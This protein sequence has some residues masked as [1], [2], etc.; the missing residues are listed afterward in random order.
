[1][2]AHDRRAYLPAAVRSALDAGADEVVVVRNFDGPIDGCEGRFRDVRCDA[3]ETNEKEARG[4]EAATG[5]IVGFLDDD[6]LWEPGKGA[7]MRSAFAGDPDLVYLCHPQVPI[8]ADGRSTVARHRELAEKHPDRFATW[9]GRDFPLLVTSIW[10]G[11]NSST[12][13]R[14]AWASEWL[15]R[16]RDA[17]WAADLFWLVAAVESGRPFR[18][19]VEALTRLRLHDANMS[20]TRGASRSEFRQRHGVSSERFAR[21]TRV[22]TEIALE[23]AGPESSVTRYLSDKAAAFRFFAALEEGS[24]ARR[25]A[26]IARHEGALR[27]D[28]AVRRVALVA[29]FSPALA[30]WL[31][32]RASRRRW[33]LG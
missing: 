13:V 4:V 22:L 8:A 19:A 25:A 2:T 15:P 26:R 3:P 27:G 12:V 24:G 14:R 10:P 23:R 28:P 17:G 5:E 16:F 29:R 6:D 20:Q 18:I 9:D 31:L 11:N 33:S 32:Y 30:R 1:M 21:A 7:A